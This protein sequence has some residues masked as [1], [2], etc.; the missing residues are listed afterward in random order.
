MRGCHQS[1]IRPNSLCGRVSRPL[2]LL[3]SS[4]SHV[5]FGLGARTRNARGSLGESPR[6]YKDPEA[7]KQMRHEEEKDDDGTRLDLPKYGCDQ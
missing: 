7:R 4:L 1:Q 5:E 6:T 2:V 3:P